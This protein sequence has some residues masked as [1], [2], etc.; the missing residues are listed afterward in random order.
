MGFEKNFS[1]VIVKKK[2]GGFTTPK[3]SKAGTMANEP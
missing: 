1:Q 2:A 3:K